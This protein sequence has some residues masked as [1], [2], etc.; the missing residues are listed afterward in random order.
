MKASES[1]SGFESNYVLDFLKHQLNVRASIILPAEINLTLRYSLQDREGG[2]YSPVEGMEIEFLPIHLVGAS[3]TKSFLDGKI[4]THIRVENVL[5]VKVHDIG[6][7]MLPG[8]M[9][10]GGLT[11]AFD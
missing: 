10:R 7:V 5:D 8:R 11:F 1:S 3:L 4:N 6:N 2:Y 9:I